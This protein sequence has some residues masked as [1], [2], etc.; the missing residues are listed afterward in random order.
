MIRFTY[1]RAGI[2]TLSL[3]GSHFV[4]L[5]QPKAVANLILDAAAAVTDGPPKA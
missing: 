1:R 2:T 5:S 3:E 4:M